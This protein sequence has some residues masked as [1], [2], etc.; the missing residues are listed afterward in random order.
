MFGRY[1]CELGEYGCFEVGDFG[2]GFDYEVDVGEVGEFGAGD[3]AAADEVCGFA[4]D[5]F[6]GDVFLEEFVFSESMLGLIR[7]VLERFRPT[8]EFETLL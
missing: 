6:F 5:A 1:L 8:G 2:D 7:K 4:G 3:E